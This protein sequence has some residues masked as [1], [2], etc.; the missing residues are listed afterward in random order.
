MDRPAPPPTLLQQYLA[1]QDV[2][3]PACGYNLRG[4]TSAACPE[5]NSDLL[6]RVGLVEPRLGAYVTGLVGWSMGAGFNL[7]LIVYLIVVLIIE[8][9]WGPPLHPFL[10]HHVVAGAAQLAGLAAWIFFLG[11]RIRR[12]GFRARWPLAASG[13]VVSLANVAVFSAIIR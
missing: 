11:R 12:P 1:E 5:C 3:C 6:L 7:L 13:W 9:D 4:L 8:W 2:P 10:T